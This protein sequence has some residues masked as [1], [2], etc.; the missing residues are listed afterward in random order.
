MN[1]INDILVKDIIEEIAN[2]I[3]ETGSILSF[4]DLGTGY[5]TV[6]VSNIQSLTNK[7]Y[8][9]ISDT[10]NFNG[11]N[12]K[13][14][15]INVGANTFRI[16]KT[17]GFATET[18]TWT[19][20]KPYFICSHVLTC[21]NILKEKD[22]TDTYKF[23]K[24]PL[25]FLVDEIENQVNRELTNNSYITT[26]IKI[27]FLY[28]I[29]YNKTSNEPETQYKNIIKPILLPL[30][31]SFIVAMENSPKVV[32]NKINYSYQIHTNYGL[33]STY[34]NE[35]NIFPDWLACIEVTI[36]EVK[37]YKQFLNCTTL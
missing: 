11:A 24:Y 3:N 33:S 1:A 9:T 30:K 29:D 7:D 36:P 28:T 35:S 34:G 32:G 21:A 15:N 10:T 8:I 20:N 2:S 18:G 6:L 5:Y 22:K 19:A 16:Q 12:Y 17:T 26:S 4:T 37:I 23:Q 13:I 14:S 31:E 27:L 25:I